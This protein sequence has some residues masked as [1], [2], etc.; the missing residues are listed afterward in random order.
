M[1][2]QDIWENKKE[3]LAGIKNTIRKQ[4]YV[5][6]I[7][8]DRLAICNACPHQSTDCA[9]LIKTCC[10]VCGCSLNFKTRSLQSS[11]PEG[12]WPALEEKK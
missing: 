9:A 12:H 3:I 11:C 8:E 5:E 10:S 1:T 7:A 4:A 6:E 2:P